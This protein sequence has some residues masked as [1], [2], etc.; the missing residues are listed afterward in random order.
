[1]YSL[2]GYGSMI[3]DRV[4]VEAY[5]QAL[6]KTVRD[7]SVVVE[8]GTGPGIFAVLASQVGAGRV[9]AIE[10]DEIIQVAREIAAANN[11]TDKITFFEDLSTRV[12]L[13]IRADVIL[14]DLR[15]VLPLFERHISAIVDARNRFLAPGGTLIPQKDTLWAAIVEVPKFYGELV[16]PWD[17]NPFGQDLSPARRLVVNN[18][19]RLRVSPDQLLTVHQLW[20]TLD[21]ASIEN[22]DARGDLDWR[23]ERAGIGHGILLWF[24]TQLTEDIG[25]SNAPGAPEAIYASLFFPWTEPVALAAGQGVGVRLEAKFVENDYVWRWST[26]IEPLAG[27]GDPGIQFEQ[28]QLAGAVL[29]AAR[30]RRVAADHVPHLSEEGCLRRRTFELMDGKASLDEIAQR[31]AK[32]F[33]KRFASWEQALS[34]AG[35]I[36]QKH[37]Q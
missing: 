2:D 5:A 4:R 15:G 37:S 35:A 31:L 10:P 18:F 25:F 16:D 30:L 23:V 20:T 22:Q 14:S 34:Y 6:R 8:I 1:M 28:S 19:Q 29:S 7:G 36:S 24:D 33:P 11:C 12:T 32:D 27:S 26:R 9:Y 3:A 17:H 13:P 21:Y